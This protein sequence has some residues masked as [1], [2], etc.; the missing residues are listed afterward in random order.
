MGDLYIKRI[1]NL[2]VIIRRYMAEIFPIRCK[3]LSNQSISQD[4]IFCMGIKAEML[5]NLLHT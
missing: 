1:T 5:L 2:L 4:A 3:T